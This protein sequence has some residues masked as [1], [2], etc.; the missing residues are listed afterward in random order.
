MYQVAAVARNIERGDAQK[1]NVSF[2]TRIYG[3]YIKK[4]MLLMVN[5]IFSSKEQITILSR[6][7]PQV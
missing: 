6:S 7:R 5:K 3:K 1:I 2:V 4:Q